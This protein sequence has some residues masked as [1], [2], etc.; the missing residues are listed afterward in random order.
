MIPE[1]LTKLAQVLVESNYKLPSGSGNP[2]RDS[3]ESEARIISILQNKGLWTLYSPNTESD[4]ETSWY[5]LKVEGYYCDIKV[6]RFESADNTSAKDAIFYFITGKAG[7]APR[8]QKDF[9]RELS[10]NESPDEKRD[11]YFIVV[12]KNAPDVFVVSLKGLANASP[13]HNNFPF[14][15][16]WD[17]CRDSTNRTWKEARD[18]L[19]GVCAESVKRGIRTWEG[20]MP[21]YYPE[22][23][24]E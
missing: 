8:P 18:F 13:T 17:K 12:N 11:F 1:T 5:D 22:F 16:N 21:K 4:N 24:K 15:C 14:Q 2:R 20:G 7:G 10:E 23:F 3:A 19:L 9:F 6:S